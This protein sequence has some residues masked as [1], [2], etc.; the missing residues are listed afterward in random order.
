MLV[1]GVLN[2]AQGHPK[3]LELANSRAAD[4]DRLA[5]LIEAGTRRGRKAEAAG[6]V[7]DQR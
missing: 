7:V 1:R 6:R 3:L 2:I 5:K 4:L